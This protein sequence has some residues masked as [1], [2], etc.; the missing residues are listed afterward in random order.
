MPEIPVRAAVKSPDIRFG[1]AAV[2][3]LFGGLWGGL[4][5]GLYLVVAGFG[6]GE[7]LAQT[8]SRFSLVEP[9]NA[10]SGVFAHLAVASLYG[11]IFGLIF[12]ALLLIPTFAARRPLA[13]WLAGVLYGLVL[14]A[15]SW[16]VQLQGD[17][18][19]PGSFLPVHWA[20][21]HLIYGF[22]LGL[23]MPFER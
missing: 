15:V 10:I 1:D 21:A 13:S 14:L 9:G 3:G 7:S 4:V 11:T 5:M 12:R 18:L 19:P 8:L 22:V 2:D 16:F 20:V 17:Q 6:L 23:S